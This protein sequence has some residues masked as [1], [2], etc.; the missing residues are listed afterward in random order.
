MRCCEVELLWD[1][2]RSGV[3]PRREHVLAH[4]R[5][6]KSCQ[7]LYEQYEG[8]AYCLSCLPTVEPPPSLVPKILEHINA[9]REKFKNTEP[10]SLSKIRSPLGRL[11]VAWRDQKI[12]FVGLERGEFETEKRKIEGRLHRPVRPAEAPQWLIE[13]VAQWFKT[14]SVDMRYIDMTQL[15]EFERAALRKAAEIPP[16]EVRSYS[17]IAREIGHPRAARAVGQAMAR[18]PVALFFPCQRVVSTNGGLNNYG[19][20]IEIKAR[21]LR[22]EGYKRA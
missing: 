5:L 2:I 7:H 11:L 16:G 17:W 22:M 1:E 12:T 20:G 3:K 21:L 18:N 9:Y 15:T 13:T 19:Y 14:W 8:I 4:L 6:C 10:D